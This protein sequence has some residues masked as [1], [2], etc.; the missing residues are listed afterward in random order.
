MRI[1]LAGVGRIGA[2]HAATLDALPAVDEV[3]VARRRRRTLAPSV[4]ADLGCP[5]APDVEALLGRG[6]RRL[7]DRHR[8]AAPRG[9]DR[10]RASPPG[11]RRSARSRWRATLAET[12]DV[13]RARRG[14]RTCRC[15]SASSAGSTPATG[16]PG[17]AVASRRARLRPHAS[18]RTRTTG[19]PPHAGVHPDQRRLLPRLHRARL[20]HHPVRHRARGGQRLRHRREPRARPSSA[21]PATSTPA[22][23][24]LTLD[25]GTFVSVSAHPLQRRRP[26]RADGGARRR[27]A[28]SPSAWTTHS[29]C[30]R[31]RPGVDLPRGAA[32]RH[33]HGALPAGVR[34][35]ADRLH[36]GRRAATREPVHRPR[37]ARGVPGRRGLRAV[38]RARAARRPVRDP[39]T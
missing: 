38:P 2:F 37:R 22:A 31:P 1:G 34:R 8:D 3:V 7:R 13:V 24:L 17:D 6:P 11:S 9:A 10:A 36:R 35:R 4:A 28:R 18:G 14:H 15:T 26:R 32:A 33:L 23:A 30:G 20:R 39:A 19:V 5:C 16:A 12:L 25:D 21:R 27:R 29:R